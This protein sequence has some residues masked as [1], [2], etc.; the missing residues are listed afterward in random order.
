MSSTQ[1]VIV[2]GALSMV[3][4]LSRQVPLTGRRKAFV[5]GCRL[6]AIVALC[7]G[8]GGTSCRRTHQVARHVV[9]LVDGSASIDAAQR[10][11]MAR[12][13]ASLETL[14]PANVE[15]AIVAFGDDAKV[16][17]PF[18]RERLTEPQVIAQMLEGA[19]II[20]QQTR[21]EGALLAAL[22]LLPPDR[23]GSIVLLSDGWET[24]G[25]VNEVL[26][27]VRRLGA[28]TFPVAPPAAGRIKTTWEELVVPPVVQRGASVPVQ[29]VVFN[30][31]SQV[32]SADVNVAM[33]GI[34][35]ASRRVGIRPGWQVVNVPV[36]TIQR[37]TMAL[38]VRL[39]ISAE[40]MVETRRA[41]TEV[42]GP[43]Q[44]LLVSD[45]LTTLP[46]LA[47][48]LKRRDMEVAV[49]RPSDLTP[50][51]S[52][53]L[54]YDAIML[55]NL[56]KSSLSQE[57]VGAL[58]T[59]IERFGGG[60]MT[61]GLGGDLAHETM[62]P[63]P[64][65][66]L[67]PITF[68]PKGLQEAKRRVCMLL[69]IDRSASMVGARIAATKRAAVE[70]VKQLAPEDLV[71]VFAFDTQP[72]VVAEVQPAGQV[73]D[74]LVEKLVKLRS[75]GGTDIYPSLAMAENRLELTGA[76][77]KHIML[78]SD[79]ITPVDMKA[80]RALFQL[81]KSEHISISTIGIGAAFINTDYLQWLAIATGGS[82]YQMKN[83]DELP[84]LIAR[85]TQRELGK[86]PFTEGAFAPS[87]TPTTDWFADLPPFPTLKGFL[88]ATEKPGAR[89]DVIV[90]S[91]EEKSPLLARWSLGQG[92]VVS[93]TSDA[94]TRWSP[95]WIRWPGFDAAWAQ[96]VRWAMRPRLTEEL[97]VWVDETRGTPQLMV[98]GLLQDPRTQLLLSGEASGARPLA[99]IQTDT[100]RWQASLEQVPSGWYQL[101][102]ESRASAE[103]TPASSSSETARAGSAA[104]PS[105][106]FAKRWIRVGTP[107]ASRE[108]TGQPPRDTVLR[109]IA[110]STAGA[111]EMPDAAFVPPVTT[112]TTRVSLLWWWLPLAIGALL[113]EIAL[114]GSSML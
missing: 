63:A 101:V 111:Y 2:L 103:I 54:D 18:G 52:K 75:S 33:Q 30:G 67:L 34:R 26:A 80:Y 7:A 45:H 16:V 47:E 23:G 58:R 50:D 102:I 36:P 109:H 98:E 70:L 27:F 71:G 6:V 51:A 49:G 48:A 89:V 86:L 10:A 85:D 110:R 88:T 53:L 21:L 19:A 61:V 14:R 41:Y 82:F 100:W 113:V 25:N 31:A 73:K 3:L 83:L 84:Q 40:G 91:A 1:L 37:G 65:D 15:R 12:R 106:I 24:A 59:Y 114:R 11:W 99:L 93:F 22:S 97:F 55:F 46:A 13:I 64:L 81:L 90:Q 72:Y 112:A 104:E 62:T 44:M 87:K 38:D 78:L 29:L 32:R 42:E 66:E 77:L 96:V 56:P 74:W 107:P 69:L 92:R 20:R 9:Y 35:I 4:W 68:E 79:G 94:D 5:I 8:L 105:R 39:T 57:Q 17:V 76:S 95:E 108:M 60:L 28:S 43:P